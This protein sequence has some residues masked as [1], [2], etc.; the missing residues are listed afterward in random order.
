MTRI[1]ARITAD[2][3][4]TEIEIPVCIRVYPRSSDPRHPRAMNHPPGRRKLSHDLCPCRMARL[5]H[6]G[7]FAGSR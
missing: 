5:P 4:N 3:K 6:A 2:Q 7:C 1:S